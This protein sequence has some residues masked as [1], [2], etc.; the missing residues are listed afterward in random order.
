MRL[1]K[2]VTLSAG[3][4][5]CGR[6]QY[7]LMDRDDLR[8]GDAE[9]DEASRALRDHWALGRLTIEEL[10]RRL[11]SVYA[12]ATRSELRA[13]TSDLPRAEAR[14]ESP[15]EVAREILLAW[16]RGLS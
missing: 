8:V 11:D 14:L 9:R 1:H 12:A 15:G 4:N 7:P 3:E 13:V 2:L 6:I 10:D 16:R 5:R